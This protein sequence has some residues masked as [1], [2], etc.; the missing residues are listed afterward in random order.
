M[1]FEELKQ[2]LMVNRWVYIEYVNTHTIKFIVM[3]DY[4]DERN[5]IGLTHSLSSIFGNSYNLK[6]TDLDGNHTKQGLIELGIGLY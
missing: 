5:F 3:F 6:I 2:E 1:E 4:E